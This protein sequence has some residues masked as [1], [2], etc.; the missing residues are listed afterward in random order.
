MSWYLQLRVDDILIRGLTWSKLLDPDKKGQWWLSKDMAA[1]TENVVEVARTI[2]KEV[3]EA[4]NMLQLASA[5]GMNT[6]NRKAI[7]CIIMTAEDYIDTIEKLLRLDLPAK[8][9]G[10]LR[11]FLHY[12]QLHLSFCLIF[13]FSAYRTERLYGFLWCVV[14]MRNISINITRY[15][16]PSCVSMTKTTSLLCRYNFL[17]SWV[18]LGNIMWG[19]KPMSK[20]AQVLLLVWKK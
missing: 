16:H 15:W 13:L 10:I 19:N 17:H 7:F 11:L 18:G 8:Q 12:F 14:C 2:D 3:L 9:V 4:Q 1:Q 20:H 6:E 5:M